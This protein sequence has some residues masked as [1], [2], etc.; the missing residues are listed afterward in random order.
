MPVLLGIPL[1]LRFLVGLTPL[2]IG[3]IASFIA[4][5]ATRTGLIALALVG[6]IMGIMTLALGWLADII[7]SYFP[8]DFSNLMASVLPD[9]TTHCITAIMSMK[10]AVMI[11]DIKDRFLSMANKVL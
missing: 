10:I 9:G 2:F 8:P 7:Y 6:A 11:F 5:L 1:L 4:R 3:Y